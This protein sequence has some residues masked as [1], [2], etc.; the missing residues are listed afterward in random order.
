MKFID[1]LNSYTHLI[2]TYSISP[3]NMLFIIL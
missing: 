3:G 1:N 2:A